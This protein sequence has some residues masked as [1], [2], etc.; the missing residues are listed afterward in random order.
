MPDRI[1]S[2]KEVSKHCKEN[3]CWVVYREKVY[4]VSVFLRDHPGGEDLILEYGGKD[5]TAVMRET[6]SHEHSD[7]AYDMMADYCIGTLGQPRHFN[8]KTREELHRQ[9]IAVLEQESEFNT[10]A[11]DNFAPAVTNAAKDT[12]F[13]DLRR[14]LIPQFFHTQ[15]TREFYLEQVHK[16]RYLPTPAIFFGHPLLEPLTK[17]KWYVVPT[18]WIPFV[19]Y[20]LHQCHDI[21][22][23]LSITAGLFASG[24]FIWSLLE[25]LLH[26]CLFHFDDHLPDAQW[27]FLLHFTL[28]GFHHF[29]PMDR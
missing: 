18:L 6:E 7:A 21:W 11:Q 16:P 23:S 15:F 28:H 12:A 17:T 24:V 3:S 27:A 1:Y 5:V 10:Y 25:Y 2:L 13:L 29:L 4:D 19:L 20:Q 26:R 22:P 14:A 8:D 9:R